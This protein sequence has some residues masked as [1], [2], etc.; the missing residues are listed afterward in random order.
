MSGTENTTDTIDRSRVDVGDTADLIDRK[1]RDCGAVVCPTS[2]RHP[3][4]ASPGDQALPTKYRV[5][6]ATTSRSGDDG[7][8]SVGW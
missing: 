1:L 2:A 6:T 8:L 7:M 3:N 5:S 4:G